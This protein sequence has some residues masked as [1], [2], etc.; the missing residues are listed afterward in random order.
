MYKIQ[1]EGHQSL[2]LEDVYNKYVPF[3]T[4]G[5]LVEFGVGHTLERFKWE[6]K[7]S[8]NPEQRCGN[9]TADLLDLGWK[10][11]YVEPIKEFCDEAK[12]CHK[13]NLDRLTI[14]NMGAGDKKET[15]TINYGES[16]IGESKADLNVSYLG[17]TIESDNASQILIDNECPTTI[18]VMS[19]DVEGYELKVLEGI[20]FDK[21]DIKF[22]IIEHNHVGLDNVDSL[23]SGKYK[24]VHSDYL[25]ACYVKGM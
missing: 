2:W 13:N 21:Y 11:I 5:Y 3:K 9:N 18:D 19:I 25:N 8:G 15:C 4:D 1:K 17:R 22:M 23:L 10:G 14:I 24:R 6:D 16:F 12:I 20:D 7:W